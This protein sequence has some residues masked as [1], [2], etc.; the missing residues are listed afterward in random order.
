MHAEELITSVA[1]YTCFGLRVDPPPAD[2]RNP[3][4]PDATGVLRLLT[5]S[6]LSQATLAAPS[7]SGQQNCKSQV[8]SGRFVVENGLQDGPLWPLLGA[9]GA[10]NASD[11]TGVLRLLT[12]SRLS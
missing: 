6:R 12:R 8:A 1:A 4:T 3:D 10:Q 7:A 11:A 9:L 2:F 5:R